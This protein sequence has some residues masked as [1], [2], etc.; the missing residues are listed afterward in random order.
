MISGKRGSGSNYG[1]I[2]DSNFL[3]LS[4]RT[5]WGGDHSAFLWAAGLMTSYTAWNLELQRRR[6]RVSKAHGKTP[7][8]NVGWIILCGPQRSSPVR[9]AGDTLRECMFNMRTAM[10]TT[11]MPQTHENAKGLPWSVCGCWYHVH[12]ECTQ[13]LPPGVYSLKLLLHRGAT[14]P[15]AQISSNCP[16]VLLYAITSLFIQLCVVS[17]PLCSLFHNKLTEVAGCCW[18]SI[19]AHSPPDPSFPVQVCLSFFIALVRSIPT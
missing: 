7:V 9:G 2:T 8:R 14:T 15:A 19:R 5:S 3:L 1:R 6:G 4:F 13:R 10:A 16:L 17:L 12:K 18:A 11:S